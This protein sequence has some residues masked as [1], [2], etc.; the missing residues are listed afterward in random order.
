MRVAPRDL[1]TG[2]HPRVGGGALRG[3][4]D[5]FRELGPSPR[6]RGSPPLPAVRALRSGSIP[7]W[8][9]EP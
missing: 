1:L 6:G 3:V 8:A 7:A 4:T 9:G 5:H 2:V